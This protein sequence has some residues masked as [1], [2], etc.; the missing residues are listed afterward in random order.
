[1][2]ELYLG[3]HNITSNQRLLDFSKLAFNLKYVKYLVI[4]K[5]GGTAAQSGIPE[6]SKLAFKYNKPILVLPELKDAIDLLKPEITV[7]VSQNSEKLINFSDLG[8]YS[9]LLVV[10]SGIEGSGFNKIEQSLGE[11]VKILEDA[12]DIGAVSLASFF[13]CKYSQLVEGK[14]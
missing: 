7:L 13:L 12:S 8:K 2:K 4:T 1:M 3:L 10:F 6:I 14:V 5:V 9:K 11:Y